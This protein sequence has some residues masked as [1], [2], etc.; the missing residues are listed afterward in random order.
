MT[1]IHGV[2]SRCAGPVA[3]LAGATALAGCGTG[4]TVIGADG[5]RDGGVDAGPPADIVRPV[6]ES[7]TPESESTEVAETAV[8]T[9][10]FSE[11]MAVAEGTARLT[12]DGEAAAVEL[13]WDD[14]ARELTVTPTAALA[15]RARVVLRLEADFVDLAGNT[16]AAPVLVTYEI[17]DT[18]GPRV[19]SS[20]PGIGASD[21][22]AR[23]PEIVIAFD[24]T[25]QTSAGTVRLEGAPGTVG[26]LRWRDAYTAVVPVSG[27]AYDSAYTLALEGFADAQGNALDDERLTDGALAFA[28]GEDDDAPRVADSDP[29]EGQVN[30]P[31]L[32]TESL[33]VIFDEPMDTSVATVDLDV[34]GTVVALPAAWSVDGLT[35]TVPAAGYLAPAGPHSL[36]LATLRDAA[37][38][39][40]DPVPHLG[41]DGALDFATGADDRAPIVAFSEPIEGTTSRALWSTAEI[42][43]VFDRAMVTSDTTFTLETPDGDVPVTGAWNLAGTE[44]RVD[45]SGEL[46]AAARYRVDLSG[47]ED[48]RGRALDTSDAY[49]GDGAL[50][51]TTRVGAGESCRDVLEADAATT[52][53]G[54]S[55]TWTIAPVQVEAR[56]GGCERCAHNPA[57]LSPDAVIHVRKTTAAASAGGSY[58]HVSVASDT[59]D[60]VTLEV[61]GGACDTST[62]ATSQ[63][64]CPGSARDWD[65]WLD[66]GPGDYYLW[67]AHA[68]SGRAI[69]FAGRRSASKR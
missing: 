24:E 42:L 18:V 37:G 67:V 64:A 62:A 44:L 34:S 61:L 26:A 48:P 58:L 38:N 43:L 57:Y 17:G 29:S 60:L 28:T 69:A 11:P 35:L 25:M 50:D 8:I 55:L 40:L 22:S 27:L 63:L 12:A 5:G 45:V 10:R 47:L 53:A 66:V 6:I 51:F 52:G 20:T 65:Q 33:R 21:V 46:R 15:S 32:S 19:A 4:G 31:T 59:T 56:D 23:L 1:A 39:A 9:V 2:F 54:G 3:L 7:I 36:R 49:L 41:G 13:G 68:G 14:E 16:L 30:V